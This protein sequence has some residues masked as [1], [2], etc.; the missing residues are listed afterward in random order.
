[1]AVD[2][3]LDMDEALIGHTENVLH[4]ALHMTLHVGPVEAFK[5]TY[6]TGIWMGLSLA[7]NDVAAA[8]KLRAH[9][10]TVIATKI[11]D[12]DEGVDAI[13]QFVRAIHRS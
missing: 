5:S 9:I 3:D 8:R 12:P 7:I 10:E 2:P 11:G 4:A 6:V 13:E 1:M